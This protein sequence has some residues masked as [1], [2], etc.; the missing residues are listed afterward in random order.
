MISERIKNN[1]STV[2]VTIV[3]I[4]LGIALEDA[5]SLFREIE[6]PGLKEWVFITLCILLII[7]SWIGYSSLAIVVRLVPT[8]MDAIN[9]FILTTFQ[10]TLNTF[11]TYPHFYYWLVLGAF[12]LGAAIAVTYNVY[13]ASKDIESGISIG[14]FRPIIFFNLLA[15]P[16]NLVIGYALYKE[17]FAP[18]MNVILLFSLLLFPVLWLY[19]FWNRWKK[20]IGP[21]N[22]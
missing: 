18:M 12:N 4:F 1:Y 5:V 21:S 15:V 11:I 6:S 3:S 2:Y 8:P 9:V 16:V 19:L 20:I 22:E 14:L 7:N 13:R 17:L 10:L